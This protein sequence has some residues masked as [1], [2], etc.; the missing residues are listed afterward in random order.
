MLLYVKKIR[1]QIGYH[2][3]SANNKYINNIFK[4][5]AN[6]DLVYR[7]SVLKHHLSR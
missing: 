3:E 1:N 2:M 7:M 4:G 6:V 5:Q